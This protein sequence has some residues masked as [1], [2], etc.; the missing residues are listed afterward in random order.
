M[1]T[2]PVATITA[3]RDL[4]GIARGSL[5][6]VFADTHNL[7]LPLAAT[8]SLILRRAEFVP[9]DAQQK[10]CIVGVM[11][12]TG[13]RDTAKTGLV[14][15]Q[16]EGK[17]A[18]LLDR[19]WSIG[20]QVVGFHPERKGWFTIDDERQMRPIRFADCCVGVGV[21]LFVPRRPPRE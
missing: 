19:A 16:R 9:P 18:V 12:R 13:T 21:H 11:E 20:W 3:G 17:L 5:V 2:P 15:R 14:F 6:R 7:G 4:V 8:Q 10:A 1:L